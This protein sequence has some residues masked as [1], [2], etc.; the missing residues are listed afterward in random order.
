MFSFP[1]TAA[2]LFFLLCL[3]IFFNIPILRPVL[4]FL[5][6]SLIPGYAFLRILKLD[7]WSLLDIVVFSAG[8]GL[9]I[10]ML[11]A[12]ILNSVCPA[13]NSID[14]S[15]SIKPFSAIPFAAALG[16]L[17]LVL[18]LLGWSQRN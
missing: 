16:S 4:G 11:L 13:I 1:K 15:I 14:Q 9:A 7:E 10:V 2:L 5:W 18:L 3:S 6:L 17:T 8:L 12:L